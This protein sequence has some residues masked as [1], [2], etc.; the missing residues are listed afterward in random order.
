MHDINTYNSDMLHHAGSLA[1]G[2][3][4]QIPGRTSVQNVRCSGDE[5]RLLDCPNSGACNTRFYASVGVRCHIREGITNCFL[6]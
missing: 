4:G 1:V 5:A 2:S 6:C 3:F